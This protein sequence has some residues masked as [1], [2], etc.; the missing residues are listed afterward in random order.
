MTN[1]QRLIKFREN[2]H[3]VHEDTE[4]NCDGIIDSKMKMIKG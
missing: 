1:V 3:S 4:T 2:I